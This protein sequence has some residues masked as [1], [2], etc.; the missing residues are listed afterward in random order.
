M[1]EIEKALESL[2]AMAE[3]SLV[4]FRAAIGAGATLEEAM[5]LTKIY[6]EAQFAEAARQ[7]KERERDETED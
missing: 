3:M 5:I 1:N 2:G 7:K 4:Y 6:M